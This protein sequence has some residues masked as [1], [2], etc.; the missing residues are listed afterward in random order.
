MAKTLRAIRFL[1]VAA[2]TGWGASGTARGWG[3]EAHRI[4]VDNAIEL[5]PP[6]LKPFFSASARAV[7]EAV[8]EPDTVLKEE[9]GREE[10]VRHFLNLDLLDRPPFQGIPREYDAALA[11]FGRERM[12]Q[13]GRLPWRA[14]DL[15]RE[16]TAA[17]RAGAWE[18]AAIRAGHL[19]HYVADA[20]QPL[21]ATVNF[22]GQDSC[23]LG[24]HQ[25]FEW[26]L[27]DL[28]PPGY[29]KGARARQKRAVYL[30][31]PVEVAF[32]LLVEAYPLHR[33][34]LEADR[35]AVQAVKAGEGE[36]FAVLEGRVRDLAEGQLAEAGTAVASFW[37][38]AW[39]DAGQV[40]T[41]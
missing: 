11:R 22:D 19:A 8:L 10:A 25:A 36:Y 23:N 41:P 37:I 21:H 20:T 7:R 33:E 18:A 26:R 6:G 40:R 34:I 12:E 27:I 14:A 9:Y 16:L 38:T 31:R 29:R 39:M 3:Y 15:L 2:L 30:D 13:A 35:A 17:F 32:R 5:L 24:I 4:V 1:A 28:D